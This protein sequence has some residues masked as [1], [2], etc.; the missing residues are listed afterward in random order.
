[1]CLDIPLDLIDDITCFRNDH[2]INNLLFTNLL[3]P[4]KPL[5]LHPF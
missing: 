5:P 3:N 4:K 2:F 1:M